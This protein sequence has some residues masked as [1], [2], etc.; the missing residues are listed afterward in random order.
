MRLKIKLCDRGYFAKYRLYVEKIS[1]W[2]WGW[3]YWSDTGNYE[4]CDF[5]TYEE[6]KELLIN[7]FKRQH[8]IIEIDKIIQL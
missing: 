1:L 7:K 5:Q 3:K 4:Y 2:G 6:S 8:E